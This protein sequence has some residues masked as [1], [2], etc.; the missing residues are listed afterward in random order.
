MPK[1]EDE[2]WAAQKG[3]SLRYCP[4]CK[5]F[6]KAKDKEWERHWRYEHPTAY[7]WQEISRERSGRSNL[8]IAVRLAIS[9]FLALFIIGWWLYPKDIEPPPTPIVVYPN[10]VA[11]SDLAPQGH[12]QEVIPF[13]WRSVSDP[14]GVKYIFQIDT[15]NNFSAPELTRE[16]KQKD[17]SS[18][19]AITLPWPGSG[20]YY[21]RVAAIDGKK[22][23]SSWSETAVFS[24]YSQPPVAK[25]AKN[26]VYLENNWNA[27]DITWQELI[28][29]LIKDDTD[30]YPYK[31]GSYVCA[32]FAELLHNRAEKAGIRAAFVMVEF[33]EGPG[34]ALNAFQTTDRGLIYIDCT[35]VREDGG[36]VT[37]GNGK[38]SIDCD[39][40]AY[41]QIGKNLGF[42][43]LDKAV[44]PDYTFYEQYM[45]RV[46]RY[47]ERVKGRLFVSYWE[48]YELERERKAIGEYYWEPLG[49]VKEVK[50]YW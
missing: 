22:N 8:K 12:K 42:V 2:Y 47:E 17:Y 11:I 4:V 39:K 50:V 21:W 10:K 48:Y 29:F 41:I 31:L 9:I 43:S 36:I 15:N 28:A 16:L 1:R 44:S 5:K 49:I 3:S 20:I 33:T 18:E 27:K 24:C 40:V 13:R 26:R 14:S 32:D 45:M 34:H 37:F 46:R 35:G 30:K 7:R 25:A 38:V 19:V 6:F 23:V